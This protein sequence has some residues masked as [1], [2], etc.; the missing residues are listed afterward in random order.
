M[1]NVNLDYLRGK[2]ANVQARNEFRYLIYEMKVRADDLSIFDDVRFA[3]L[4][5]HSG[6]CRKA[7]DALA[8]RLC[9]SGWKNDNFNIEQIFQMNNPDVFFDSAI[10]SALITGCA[11]VYISA[12]PVAKI[13]RLEVIDGRNATG[14][15][16]PT[17]NLLI[18]GYAILETDKDGNPT[19]EAHF[20]P[21][22]TTFYY[23]ERHREPETIKTNCEH[24]LLVPIIFRP[25]AKKPFGHSRISRAMIDLIGCINRTVK[26]SEI[27]SEFYSFPQKYVL[28]TSPNQE[29]LE[30]WRATVSTLL[31]VTKDEDGDKP[32]V[33]QFTQQSMQPFSD[34]MKMLAALFAGE[35]GLSVDDLGFVSENP[36]SAEAIKAGHENLRLTARK[37]QRTFGSCFLNVGY[38]AACVRD[39]FAYKRAQF[40]Q[41]KA[42]WEP[43]F[44]PDSAMLSGIGDG[45]IKV[46]QA[47][48]G[49]FNVDNLREL[50]GIAASDL[51][52]PTAIETAGTAEGAE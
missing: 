45:A 43:I 17:T 42:V 34:Q 25:D 26:R 32:A 1:E 14:I 9:L 6:W 7:V 15:I 44:E 13:P 16:D 41:T 22:E 2:L 11:F 31:E 18:E 37:A 38:L 48:P 52:A 50:T 39:G 36:S 33:G 10:V 20:K 40:Y 5:T 51:P 30:K 3:K 29:P 21:G 19:I 46:N 35:S 8:D 28:G 23:K 4:H 24:P 49:Y 12:D 47:V 27:C